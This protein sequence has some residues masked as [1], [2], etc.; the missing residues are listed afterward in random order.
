MKLHVDPL[1]ISNEERV[2]E[3][4]QVRAIHLPA[5]LGWLNAI[6]QSNMVG[7]TILAVINPEHYEAGQKTFMHLRKDTEIQHQDIHHVLNQ[8][9]SA[10]TGVSIMH[11]RITPLY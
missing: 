2:Q 9:T 11:N 6:S 8:W 7:S 4:P 5:G 10:F 3:R 1:L